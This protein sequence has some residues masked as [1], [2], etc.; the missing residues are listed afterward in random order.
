MG[1][2]KKLGGFLKKAAKVA[3]PMAAGFAV[4]GAAN[5]VSGLFS[6][7]QGAQTFPVDDHL[8]NKPPAQGFDWKGAVQTATPF[9]M[10][11]LNYIG[12]QQTNAANAQMAQRQM[13]FQQEMSSTAYQR[14]T[15]DMKAAGLN[16]MLG[17]SQGGAS[18]P[19]GASAQMGNELGEGA[20]SALSAISTMQELQ[21]RAA[22][23]ELTRAQVGATQ[24]ESDLTQ[25]KRMDVLEGIP[26]H[27]TERNYTRS[28]TEGQHWSNQLEE[29]RARL[30]AESYQEQFNTLVSNAKRAH[31]E[32]IAAD[33]SLSEKGAYKRYWDDVGKGGVYA[34]E[35]ADIISK[36]GGSVAKM[37]P[38]FRMLMN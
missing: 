27:S 17:Y 12:Q 30:M 23:I 2:F 3:L 34:R 7:Q 26:T 24:A 10:G 16:P 25:A 13:D 5:A 29:L 31:A 22:Q 33:Y 19:G 36:A 14:G 6:A 1:L 9:V 35:G 21:S 4:P 28:R 18:S 11:G 15:A 8:G 38:G 20:N 32:A 37:I